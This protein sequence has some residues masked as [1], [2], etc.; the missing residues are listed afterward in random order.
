[1]ILPV[2]APLQQQMIAL[3]YKCRDGQMLLADPVSVQLTYRK[4]AS[5]AVDRRYDL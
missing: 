4:E 3:K 1:M 5:I 2:R